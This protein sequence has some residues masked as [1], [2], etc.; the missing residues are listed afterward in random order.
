MQKNENRCFQFSFV[1]KNTI[2]VY[3]CK[4][5]LLII[6]DLLIFNCLDKFLPYAHLDDPNIFTFFIVVQVKLSPFFHQHSLP[7][8]PSPLPTLDPN[9]L[10]FC[11]CVLYTCSLMTLP[12]F[13]PIIPSHLRSGYCQFVLNF[14]VSGY[15]LLI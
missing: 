2:E 14:N 13:P 6:Q 5:I 1:L 10:W 12:P 7:P 9:P 3:I 15:I 11:P 4:H 8:Q